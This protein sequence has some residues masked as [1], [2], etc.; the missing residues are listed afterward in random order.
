MPLLLTA[1]AFFVY[2]PSLS[3][4]F[5]WDAR[6]EIFE[7]GF[8]TDLANLPAVLSLKVLGMPLILGDR[9]GQLLYLMLNAAVWGTNPWGYHLCSNIIHAANTGL[10]FVLALRLSKASLT[11]LTTSELRLACV[12]IAVAVLIFALHPVAVEAVAAISYSSDLLVTFFTL[13]ALL[14]ATGFRQGNIR[15]AWI[16]GIIGTLC[17]FAAVTCKESGIAASLLIAIYWLLFRRSDAKAPWL[18]F[19]VTAF[20]VTA[21]FIIARFA[22]APP[23]QLKLPYLGGSFAQ[24]FWIQPRLWVFMIGKLVWPM[25]LSADYML[26]NVNG[27]S[28]PIALLVLAVLI[29]FQ[30][31]LVLQSRVAAFGV[32]IFWFGLITVSNFM[33]LN[34]IMADRFYYLPMAGVALQIVALLLLLLKWRAVFW[35]S[36]GMLIVVLA[37]LT[38]LTL[39]RQS[40]FANEFSL[41]KDTVRASPTSA[42]AQNE[43]GA[44]L[45]RQG[46]LN[47]AMA[48]YRRAVEL[49]PN[50]TEA[51]NNLGIMLR[52][53]G[54]VDAA[55]V[56]FQKA[57]ASTP[58]YA[59]A[60]YNLGN[61][62]LAT[63]HL[64]DAISEYRAALVVNPRLVLAHNNLGNA[65]LKKGDFDGAIT[66]YQAALEIEPTLSMAQQNL[67]YARAQKQ[68]SQNAVARPAH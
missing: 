3:S 41:W 46:D 20:V 8:L 19:V 2:W 62:W 44:A 39:D 37:P 16:L 63:G 29:S 30:L 14:A 64:D 67:A 12:A 26:E 6:I 57:A 42:I 54:N 47:D 59:A 9:P 33:P 17:S 27:L 11:D 32:A 49:S 31:W 55:I 48:Y 65:L 52:K 7:E 56:E 13:L 58:P 28:T 35:S 4:D 25:N 15:S 43:F 23:G 1:I 50:Y 51:H 36:T 40:V 5:V 10:L 45:S 22:V 66:E 68:A 53:Q 21:A 24:V 60:H 38:L 18:L 34:R 61:A